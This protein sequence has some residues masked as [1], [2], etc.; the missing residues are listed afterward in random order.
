MKLTIMLLIIAVLTIYGLIQIKTTME[1]N[2]N[3]YIEAI[4]K[5]K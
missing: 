2:V 5:I 4:E 3:K 1:K